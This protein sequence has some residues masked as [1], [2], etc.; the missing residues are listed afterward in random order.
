MRTYDGIVPYIRFESVSI[1]SILSD[2]TEGSEPVTRFAVIEN[3]IISGLENIK[4]G[5]VPDNK[6]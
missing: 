2:I 6:L 3:C 5:N 4:D 1:N